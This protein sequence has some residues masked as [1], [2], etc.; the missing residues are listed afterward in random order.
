MKAK[1][2]A[3]FGAAL[4]ACNGGPPPPYEVGRNTEWA[5]ESAQERDSCSTAGYCYKC[6]PG[7]CG[8]KFSALCSGHRQVTVRYGRETVRYSD[9]SST[10]QNV[11]AVVSAGS[12]RR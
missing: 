12:C 4:T 2:W 3:L 9:G 7:P 11:R 1:G 10:T 6:F 8:F 5:P